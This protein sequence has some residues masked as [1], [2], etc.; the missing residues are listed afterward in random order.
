MRMRSVLLPWKT[1]WWIPEQQRC[2]YPV[3]PLIDQLGLDL[4]KEVDVA[5]SRHVYA[6]IPPRFE[7]EITEFGR[8]LEP[9]LVLMQEWGSSFKTRRLTEED[10]QSP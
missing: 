4:L 8:T 1:L 2:A 7:Y 9:I 6:E 3:M 10:I 5:I